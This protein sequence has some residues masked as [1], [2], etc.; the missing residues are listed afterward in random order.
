MRAAATAAAHQ[1]AACRR[2]PCDSAEWCRT[3]AA[4]IL[5]VGPRIHAC[6]QPLRNHWQGG[7]G[8]LHGLA[9][10]LVQA[11]DVLQ[12][13][14]QCHHLQHAGA[15][16]HVADCG[17]DQLAVRG[18]PAGCVTVGS[19]AIEIPTDTIQC[20]LLQE[21]QLGRLALVS[22]KGGTPLEE[23]HHVERGDTSRM[24]IVQGNCKFATAKQ[25]VG[26]ARR[27]PRWPAEQWRVFEIR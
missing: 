1:R 18:P 9:H 23:L 8:H 10:Q 13:A 20:T 25:A 11:G 26:S 12:G 24:R 22:C 16:Q 5:A 7:S 17:G 4:P 19:G 27:A 15:L 6:S 2:Q 14:Q 21:A 3:D